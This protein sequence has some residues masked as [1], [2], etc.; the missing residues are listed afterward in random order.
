MPPLFKGEAIFYPA[1]LAKSNEI[2][3]IVAVK[4]SVTLFIFKADGEDNGTIW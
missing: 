2:S 1:L 4:K 3:C